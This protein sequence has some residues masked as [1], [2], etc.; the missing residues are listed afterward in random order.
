MRWP[1]VLVLVT[2]KAKAARSEWKGDGAS[3]EEV[4]F[5]S[6][7]ETKPTIILATQAGS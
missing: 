5:T 6:F 1:L 7:E 2:S 4:C 3:A